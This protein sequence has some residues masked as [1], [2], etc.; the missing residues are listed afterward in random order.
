MTDTIVQFRHVDCEAGSPYQYKECGLSNIWLLSG[1]NKEEIDGECYISVR[2]ADA[3]HKQIAISLITQKHDLEGPQVR[4][5]RKEMDL[6]QSEL[7]ALLDVNAQ[8]VARYEKGESNVSGP[9]N[10]LIRLIALDH[11][12]GKVEVMKVAQEL[13][14]I[15]ELLYTDLTMSFDP[16]DGWKQTLA[17]A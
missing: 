14:A 7:A 10:V 6:T 5:L 16:Q 3:L 2:D 11:F 1:Y 8:T 17:A 9:A 12:T 15:D 13:Q 4:F